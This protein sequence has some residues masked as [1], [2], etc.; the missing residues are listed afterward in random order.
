MVEIKEFSGIRYNFV[1]LKK[2]NISL[3]E[4]VCPPYDIISVELYKKLAKQKYN[5]VHLEFPEGKI[6][7]SKKIFN[8]TKKLFTSWLKSKI[9]VQSKIPSVYISE[10][11]FVYPAGSQN[12]YKRYGIYCIV[13]IDPEYKEILPHEETKQ[14]PVEYRLE[15]LK[16]LLTQTSPVFFL[17]LDNGE[18]SKQIKKYINIL[19]DKP[20]INFKD[21]FGTEHKIWSIIGNKYITELKKFF[22]NKKLVIADGHHRYRTAVEF[23]REV[24]NTKRNKFVNK[25]SVIENAGYVFGYI[26]SVID[27]GLL[28]LPTHRSVAGKHLKNVIEKNFDLTPWDGKSQVKLVLY[29]SGEF[30]VMLPKKRL[31][32]TDYSSQI[33]SVLLEETVLKD[34]PKEQIFYHQDMKEVISYADKYN[35]YA[36]LVEP[37]SKEQFKNIVSKKIVLPPKSTYFYPKV[38]AG[39]VCYRLV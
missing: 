30:K 21:I 22:E 27:D 33:S 14:K 9:L 12:V 29:D 18:L 5:F 11:I 37:V 38:M 2:Q 3:G 15:L 20:D 34:V 32:I 24:S 26:C 31:K 35:G 25:K 7:C 10:E 1:K 13:K 39:G 23:Y 8:E 28:I 19:G 4:L 36:F 16:I 6:V 17:V